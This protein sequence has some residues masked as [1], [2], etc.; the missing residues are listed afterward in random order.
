MSSLVLRIELLSEELSAARNA[1]A[2]YNAGRLTSMRAE[3][4][5]AKDA[6]QSAAAELRAILDAVNS[7]AR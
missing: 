2:D 4:H 7:L 3:V 5:R 1:L 6:L